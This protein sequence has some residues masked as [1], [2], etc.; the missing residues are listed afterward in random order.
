MGHTDLKIWKFLCYDGVFCLEFPLLFSVSNVT[1]AIQTEDG[2]RFQE[3]FLPDTS[4][5]D[6][7]NKFQNQM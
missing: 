7:I 4:L 5:T 2:K 1:L 6:I 3:D